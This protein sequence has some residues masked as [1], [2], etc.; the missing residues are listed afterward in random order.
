MSQKKKI[1]L[2]LKLV[3]WFTPVIQ[4]VLERLGQENYEFEASLSYIARP[5]SNRERGMGKERKKDKPETGQQAPQC[6]LLQRN[7]AGRRE[8]HRQPPLLP[9]QDDGSSPLLSWATVSISQCD[10]AWNL[11]EQYW[12]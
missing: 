11:Q 3:Q 1:R 12:L 10:T 5:A 6:L 8:G 9:S 2:I 4:S 7:Q